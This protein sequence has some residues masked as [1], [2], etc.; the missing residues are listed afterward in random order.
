MSDDRDNPPA[1]AETTRGELV[2]LRL[3][4][5]HSSLEVAS[6]GA[7]VCSWQLHHGEPVLFMSPK[8]HFLKGKAIRGGVPVIFPWFGKRE[9][10]PT[11]PQ[12][13]FGRVANWKQTRGEVDQ[14]GAA[15]AEFQL[16]DN[17]S[18]RKS[19]PF[20]FTAKLTIEGQTQLRITLEIQNTDSKPFTFGAGLHSYFCVSD[21]ERIKILGLEGTEYIDQVA[22]NAVRKQPNYAITFD[23]ELDRIYFDTDA[24][25]VIHDPGNERRI[26]IAKSGSKST[27]VWNPWTGKAG[28]MADLGADNWRGMVCVETTNAGPDSVTLT[29]QATHRLETTISVEPI[30]AE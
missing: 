17:D 15:V 8:S 14:N 1:P 4:G 12:H 21:I 29:P 11:A 10:D 18:T 13:G 7:H 16:K 3:S 26:V 9:D 23:G 6:Q 27:V 2:M 20:S 25:C 24:T 5:A 22:A 28:S 19:W 30:P